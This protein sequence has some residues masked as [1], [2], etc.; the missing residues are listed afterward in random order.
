[1]K[2]EITDFDTSKSILFKLSIEKHL[3]FYFEFKNNCLYEELITLKKEVYNK[4]YENSI[5]IEN[6]NKYN[7]IIFTLVVVAVKK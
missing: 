2:L 7:N 1:V 4:I 3:N 6:I 5:L